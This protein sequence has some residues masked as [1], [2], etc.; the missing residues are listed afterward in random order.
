[1]IDDT[2]KDK[3]NYFSTQQCKVHLT[4]KPT[5]KFPRG[6]FHNGIVAQ[7]YDDFILFLDEKEGQI[8][9]LFFEISDI[10]K[11]REMDNG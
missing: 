9:V 3:I 7:V 1:M 2:I 6:K 8:E 4:K 11:Y 10:E 5:P